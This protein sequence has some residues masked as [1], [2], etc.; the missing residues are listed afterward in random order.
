MTN[1]FTGTGISIIFYLLLAFYM[2]IAFLVRTIRHRSIHKARFVLRHFLYAASITLTVWLGIS[3]LTR[4]L[5]LEGRG[6]LHIFI[7]LGVRGVAAILLFWTLMPMFV[8]VWLRVR[9]FAPPALPA[10]VLLAQ[11]PKVRRPR[12]LAIDCVLPVLPLGPGGRSAGPVG[13]AATKLPAPVSP[14]VSR[15]SRSTVGEQHLDGVYWSQS[16]NRVYAYSQAKL[17]D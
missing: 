15:K 5:G 14:P 6:K 1:G 2:P 9:H 11:Q 3:Y 4:V 10:L 16:G 12:Q 7:N 13:L 8:Q 17:Q